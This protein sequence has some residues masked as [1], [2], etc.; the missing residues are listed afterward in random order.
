MAASAGLVVTFALFIFA[1]LFSW[2]E[3]VLRTCSRSLLKQWADQGRSSAKKALELTEPKSPTWTILRWTV[4]GL[5]LAGAALSTGT[6]WRP[7]A[8]SIENLSWGWLVGW[9]SKVAFGL[10]V[11][12]LVVA[13]GLLVETIPKR[14]AAGLSER[15]VLWLAWPVAIWVRL[16]RPIHWLIETASKPVV[17]VVQGPPAACSSGL[18]LKEIEH[19][20]QMGATAG[21]IAPAEER[22]AQ[23][24]LRFGDRTVR[25]IMRPR[26][27]IDA[28]DVDTPPEQVIG[29]VAMAGFSRLPVYEGDIDHIIGFVYTKDL[30]RQQHLGWPIELRKLLRPALMVPGSL[31]IDRLLEMFRQKRVQMAI[32]LDEYGGTEGL[33]TL[34]DVLEELVGEIHDELQPEADQQLIQQDDRTWLVDGRMNI[35]DF[36]A[37]LGRED[38][39]STETRSFHT[40]AG[41]VLA[42]L[43]RIP[44]V[45]D[46]LQWKDFQIEVVQMNGMRIDRVRVKLPEKS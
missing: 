40:V 35:E 17:F 6:V 21:L 41:L 24:A 29:I 14:V 18:S 8:E 44:T 15:T 22:V 13:W 3:H 19:W 28:I 2:A 38:L 23:R 16:L 4:G 9:S 43:D 39:H 37:R 45:G 32:V 27:E 11:V 31:G 20:L 36:F 10:L 1:G 33:V 26:I 42:V 7:L 5:G 12:G 25:D 30:L 46:C 34:E